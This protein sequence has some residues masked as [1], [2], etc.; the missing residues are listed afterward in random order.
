M[1][2]VVV[3]SSDHWWT[4]ISKKVCR[5]V[6]FLDTVAAECLHWNG[7]LVRLTEAKA[8]GGAREFSSFESCA[9]DQK[10]AVFMLDGPIV[11][12]T[13]AD[14]LKEIVCNSSFE[15]CVVVTNA[16]PSVHSLASGG[17]EETNAFA[18]LEEQVLEWMGDDN[19]TCEIFYL[20]FHVAEISPEVFVMPAFSRLFPLLEADVEKMLGDIAPPPPPLTNS[21]SSIAHESLPRELQTCVGHFVSSL[22]S[23]LQMMDTRDDLFSVGPFSRMLAEQLQQLPAARNRRKSAP[24]HHRC[25]AL[26]SLLIS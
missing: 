9:R 6:V 4:E 17:G 18:E 11:N 14:I 1:E 15:Y 10:K 23:L 25:S 8:S 2:R 12:T 3:V 20:P 24:P 22:N 26:S 7:G 21:S 19:F 5:A 13:K 16:A